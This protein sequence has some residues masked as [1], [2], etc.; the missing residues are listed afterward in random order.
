MRPRRGALRQPESTVPVRHNAAIVGAQPGG[1]AR[2]LREF[3]KFFAMVQKPRNPIVLIPSRLAS[4][5]LPNNPLA[6]IHGEPMIVHVWR[7]G[8][9]AGGGPLV[10]PPARSPAPPP[11]PPPTAPHPPTTPPP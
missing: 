1:A 2:P 3:G 5:R 11:P 8:I 6:D 4:T 9:E 7:R 10:G